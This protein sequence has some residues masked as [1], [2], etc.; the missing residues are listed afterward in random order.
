MRNKNK[1]VLYLFK[2]FLDRLLVNRYTSAVPS[3]NLL[4]KRLIAY[5]GRRNFK[6]RVRPPFKIYKISSFIGTRIRG[7]ILKTKFTKT[8]KKK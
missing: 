8:K 6:L 5:T 1:P 7:S 4:G 3:S 2:S